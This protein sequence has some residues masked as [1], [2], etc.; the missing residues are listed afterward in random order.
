[1]E[2]LSSYYS[3]IARHKMNC[4]NKIMRYHQR[5]IIF[6]KWCSKLADRQADQFYLRSLR[7]QALGRWIR[8][9]GYRYRRRMCREQAWLKWS[10]CLQRRRQLHF[11]EDR[12]HT[13]VLRLVFTRW[14][15]SFMIHHDRNTVVKRFCM[16]QWKL[17]WFKRK[18]A[19]RTSS[20]TQRACWVWWRLRAD[21]RQRRLSCAL[22]ATSIRETV[23][24][25][26]C[27]RRWQSR[28]K[29][30]DRVNLKTHILNDLRNERVLSICFQKWKRRRRSSRLTNAVLLV[31]GGG[32]V[33]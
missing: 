20:Q 30:M 12:H 4:V 22:L 33:K 17:A 13:H 29:W 32:H 5:R 25:V 21:Q 3:P 31:S 28:K 8:A 14:I 19:E 23:L 26:C 27:L 1:M 6:Q 2:G 15:T 11:A 24:L 16:E 18:L 9:L 10:T 7:E